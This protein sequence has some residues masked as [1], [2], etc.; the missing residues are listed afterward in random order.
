MEKYFSEE[1]FSGL[2][3]RIFIRVFHQ[4]AN[5]R[6]FSAEYFLAENFSAEYFFVEYFKIF[7]SRIFQNISKQNIS[8]YFSAEY[9][10][11]FLS[12][13]FQNISL[14]NISMGHQSA[15][16]SFG[17]AAPSFAESVAQAQQATVTFKIAFVITDNKNTQATA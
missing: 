3:V 10:K 8:K 4:S 7:L 16:V 15:S 11:I 12:R 6:Y 2:S 13:I 1:Y 5:C 9:F 14:Q 17:Q